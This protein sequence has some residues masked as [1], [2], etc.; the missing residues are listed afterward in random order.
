MNKFIINAKRIKKLNDE[1]INP[2]PKETQLI[3]FI[4]EM[5]KEIER[6]EEYE[7]M[8]KDLCK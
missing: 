6:L 2:N 8:Y 3:D 5:S 4:I 7:W 1:I